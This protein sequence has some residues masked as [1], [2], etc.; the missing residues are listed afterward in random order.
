MSPTRKLLI[1]FTPIGWEDYQYWQK[2]DRRIVKRINELIR[3]IIRHPFD[4]KGKPEALKFDLAG[5]WSRRINHEHRI[6][7]KVD[8]NKI[9]IL[10]CRHHY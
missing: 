5:F 9:V 3:E 4:G 10:Q 7:Y 1:A 2:N 8:D 6:V